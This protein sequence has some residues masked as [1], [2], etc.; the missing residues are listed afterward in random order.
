MSLKSSL[1]T[2]NEDTFLCFFVCH[3]FVIQPIVDVIE[4]FL[5]IYT[6]CLHGFVEE[7]CHRKIVFS[8]D[9]FGKKKTDLKTES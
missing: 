6:F 1:F 3:G 7:L 9:H 5:I 4:A 2:S 8:Q